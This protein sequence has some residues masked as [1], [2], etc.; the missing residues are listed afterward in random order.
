MADADSA[1]PHTMKEHCTAVIV[2]ALDT[3]LAAREHERPAES[4]GVAESP[5]AES[6]CDAPAA[7]SRVAE[8]E[9]AQLPDPVD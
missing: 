3:G 7:E 8:P 1:E 9:V 6:G 4:A 2:A 5:G